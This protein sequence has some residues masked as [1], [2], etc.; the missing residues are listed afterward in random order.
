MKK[1]ALSF[2]AFLPVLLFA[3]NIPSC[4]LLIKNGKIVDGTGN[5]WYYGDVAIS[6]GRIIQAGTALKFK[7][8]RT[9]D[10]TGLIV[11][12]GFID[13]HTHIEDDEV[14]DPTAAN[15]IYDGVTTVIT[16]NCGSSNVNIGKYLGW[17][18]SLKLSIN[19]ASLIGHNDVRKAIMGRANRDATPAE[20]EKMEQLVDKAMKDGAVGLST[21]L[22]YIPGTYTKTPEIVSLARVTA[23][24]HGVYASHMRDEGDSV[25]AAIEEALTIG[26]EANIPVQIS[27]FKLSGQQNWGRSRETVAMVEAAR[28]QGIEVTIDQYPYTASSTSIS[29]LIPDEILAD[30]QD[31]IRARLQRPE[32]REYVIKSML[33]RLKKR[34]L[35]H[36]N[37]AVVAY[38]AADTSYN[39]KSIEEINL[40]K[41]RKHKAREEAITVLDIMIAGGASAVFHG[42]GEEDVKRIM[43]Y[44]FNMFASDASIRV[45]NAGMPHPRG[46]GTNARVL[47]KYVREEKVISLEEA[48]RRMTSLPAQKF[49][50]HERGLLQPGFAADIVVFDEK[51]VTDVSTFSK[52]HAYS[53]GFH[54]VIVNGQ[55][56][57]DQEKHTGARSGKALYGQG[58]T[59]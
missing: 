28:R 53:R 3:Q 32:V 19:V 44:P 11:A 46:Y 47:G 48:I 20:L 12:P 54:F 23:R 45:L 36:F 52:P 24:Y 59:L 39:G 9:I 49:Q 6:N 38:H 10:A 5:S 15:F 42:M 17:I 22:I 29:T 16:G 56:T 27:H 58:K 51:Q 21:G 13:V 50:L 4:D 35:K 40:L 37:Y 30:G 55:V 43:Q 31:S 1:C 34:K 18:D 2:L 33:A 25:T 57:V 26:R 14:K 41:G 7:P 8:A